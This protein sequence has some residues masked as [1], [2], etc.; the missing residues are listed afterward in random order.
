M[1]Q[2]RKPRKLVR[3]GSGDSL[4]KEL[5][6]YVGLGNSNNSGTIILRET[7]V[8]VIDNCERSEAIIG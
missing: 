5:R 2:A 3:V 8:L 1:L 6:T 4:H 7:T